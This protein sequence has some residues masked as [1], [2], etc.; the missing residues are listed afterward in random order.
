MSQCSSTTSEDCSRQ[1]HGADAP[2]IRQA[3]PAAVI[4][5]VFLVL[6]WW[7]SVFS[8]V[9][10]SLKHFNPGE[11]AFL[12]LL[13]AT[14]FLGTYSIMARM[15]APGRRH[16]PRLVWIGAIG[17]AAYLTLLNLGQRTVEAGTASFIVNTTPAITAI[18]AVVFLKERLKALGILG[19]IVSLSGVGLILLSTQK[20]EA[21]D[22]IS[23]GLFLICAALAHAIHFI[24]QKATLR[25]L[26][27]LQVTLGSMFIGTVCLLPFAGTALKA[28]LEA[29]V[30]A[31][32]AVVYLGIF[33]SALAHFT[34]S[35]VLSQMTVSK[36][37][38][39]LMLISPTA[40]IMG[41]VWLGEATPAIAWCGG[42]LTIL[43]VA[44]VQ[45]KT[46]G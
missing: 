19:I 23:G 42:A 46:G 36:A 2:A 40:A 16:W 25:N 10:V 22:S 37:T 9:R 12:R 7:A 21:T 39:L 4:C 5:A 27:P 15:P 34:W 8:T 11:L 26:S 30:S 33:P 43:G 24:L 20:G 1:L 41:S 14:A 38:N 28:L 3:H 32:M 13:I 29:P 44:L 6:F 18:L 35:F 17:F 45:S 31:V